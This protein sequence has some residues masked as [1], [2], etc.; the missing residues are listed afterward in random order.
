MTSASS[1]SMNVNDNLPGPGA[2]MVGG[3]GSC[4]SHVVPPPPSVPPSPLEPSAVQG[5][6]SPTGR[7]AHRG[8]DLPLSSATDVATISQGEKNS[9]LPK[10]LLPLPGCKDPKHCVGGLPHVSFSAPGGLA[11]T[12]EQIEWVT[13][14]YMF[15][16]VSTRGDF[17]LKK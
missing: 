8:G 17:F 3:G 11:P 5:V 6:D 13:L 9:P 16:S 14:R 15:K 10:S 7:R 4:G 2:D 12:R 1:M